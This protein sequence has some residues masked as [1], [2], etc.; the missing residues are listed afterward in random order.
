MIDEGGKNPVRKSHSS[1]I[2]V[3]QVEL[4]LNKSDKP[5]NRSFNIN[6][7]YAIQSMLSVPSIF[8]MYQT[9]KEEKKIKS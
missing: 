4:S 7:A 9:F 6:K 8:E 5:Q 2:K 1:S 3:H